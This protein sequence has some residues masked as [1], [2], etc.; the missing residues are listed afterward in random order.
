MQAVP[1][2]LHPLESA[3]LSRRTPEAD[4]GSCQAA[5]DHRLAAV[6]W[7]NF[8]T[9]LGSAAAACL[10]NRTKQFADTGGKS[11]R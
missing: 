2:G 1:W 3:A 8:V 11:H 5:Y 7:C 6:Q 4:S 10:D 9:L